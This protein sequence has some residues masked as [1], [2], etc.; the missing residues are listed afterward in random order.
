[1]GELPEDVMYYIEHRF[2]RRDRPEVLLLI[3]QD[4][5]RTPRIL[6]SVLFLADG[7]LSLLEHNVEVCRK[8]LATILTNAEFI[9]G[10][11]E[12]PMPI[13]DMS[14]PFT[15]EGN[16]GRDL[17]SSILVKE[18]KGPAPVRAPGY[19]E[20]HQH[21]AQ[22]TFRLGSANYIVA[23]RQKRPDKVRCYRQQGE[24][25]RIAYLPL[26]FVLEQL[27]EHVEIDQAVSY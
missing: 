27:A 21:L 14:L 12:K 2:A 20:Y 16:L 15:H 19:T 17:M 6:R 26:V 3:D 23:T 18:A 9:V 7:S 13:R 25:T 8:D 4:H 1:M 10:V 22:A 11:T 5:L 24:S